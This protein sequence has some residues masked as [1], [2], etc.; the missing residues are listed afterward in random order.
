MKEAI[1]VAAD[2]DVISKNGAMYEFGDLKVRGL[3]A[4]TEELRKL[5]PEIVGEIERLTLQEAGV[6]CNYT[7]EDGR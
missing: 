2:Y 7:D 5:G 1:R 4:F 6:K 3:D